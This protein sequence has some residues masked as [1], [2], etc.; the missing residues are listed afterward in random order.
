MLIFSYYTNILCKTVHKK[1]QKIK[2]KLNKICI[3][4]LTVAQSHATLQNVWQKMQLLL[5]VPSL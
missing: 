4:K 1:V 5:K 3:N 2:K